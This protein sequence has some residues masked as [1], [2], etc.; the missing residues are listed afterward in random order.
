MT[1]EFGRLEMILTRE[2]S[3]VKSRKK[4]LFGVD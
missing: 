4:S 2:V 1:T 3:S